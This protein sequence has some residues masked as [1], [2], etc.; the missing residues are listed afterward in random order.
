MV[1]SVSQNPNVTRTSIFY[2][3]DIHG[4]TKNMEKITSASKNFDSFT[5]SGV[6]KLKL[7][8]GDT[9]LGHDEKLNIAANKFLNANNIMASAVGN[10]EFDIDNKKFLNIIKDSTCK[11]MGFNTKIDP[12]GQFNNKLVSSYIQESNGNKYGIIG[13]MPY[14][15]Y[16][17]IKNKP[18]GLEIENEEETTKQ[19]QAEVNKM[20]E[21]GISKIIVLSHTGYEQE[22]RLAQ[23]VEG[24]DV[25]IGGHSHDLV[26]GVKEGENLFYSKKTGEPTIITQGGRDG[27]HFGILNLMFDKDGVITDVQNNVANTNDFKRNLGIQ[28]VFDNIL[29]DSEKIGTVASAPSMP[30]KVLLTE[31]P[32]ADFI[33]DAMRKELK[34]DIAFINSANIRGAF[35][36]GPISA[37]DVSG[38]TPF[39]NKMT[40]INVTEK[41]LVDALKYTSK[42][43]LA[44]DGKPGLMQ[45]S[46]LRYTINKKGELLDL[47]FT[48][49]DGNTNKIDVNNPNIFKK[50]SVAVDDFCSKGRDG[51]G[52]LKKFDEPDTIRF[53]YDKDKI[54]VDYI[55]KQTEPIIIKADGRIQIVD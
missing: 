3:N 11:M 49:K 4:Q 29:G 20:K 1:S 10:H 48:D 26:Y 47:N 6:D 2:I 7:S 16:T 52:M 18:Q 41:E 13:L 53:D 34:T 30:E 55:K 33:A 46:G 43:V 5:P 24:I 54:T 50:Y 28:K 42:S 38:I 25:I 23:N 22:K 12:E 31:N 14:D 19:V 51:Y 36:A 17:R 40:I 15:L 27:S 8:A 32:H 21:Q 44:A 9:M 39:K 37:R 35:E 45:V